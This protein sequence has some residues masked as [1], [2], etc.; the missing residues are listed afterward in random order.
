MASEFA[1]IPASQELQHAI[2]LSAA[3]VL[4][5]AIGLERQ[6]RAK[7]AGLRTHTLVGVGSALFMLVSKF[8][9]AD[10]SNG[11]TVILDPSRVAAQVVSG[12]GFIGAGLIFVRRDDVRGLTTAASIWLTA[13]IGMAAGAGLLILA[14]AATVSHFLVVLG[15]APLGRRIAGGQAGRHE[16]HLAYT[17]GAG[18]L[19]RSLVE[20]RR[21]GFALSDVTIRKEDHGSA[22]ASDV[23]HVDVLVVGQRPV[24]DLVGV[25]GDLPGM[26]RV[27]TA[28]ENWDAA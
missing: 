28:D 23:V 2:L 11:S 21:L 7:S 12:I 3:L 24:A 22:T 17:N 9:F 20:A 13:A 4:S 16:L 19:R 8:G 26:V 1:I 25:I 15:L 10:V 14:S 6:L 5:S 27:Q 18:V